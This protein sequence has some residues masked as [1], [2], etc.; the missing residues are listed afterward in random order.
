M[1][2][3]L[4]QES[5]LM[6]ISLSGLYQVYSIEAHALFVRNLPHGLVPKFLIFGPQVIRL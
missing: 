2:S 3:R 1:L 6:L 5:L 4:L